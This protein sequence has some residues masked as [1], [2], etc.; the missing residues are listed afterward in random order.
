MTARV[1]APAANGRILARIGRDGSLISLCAPQLDH[2]LIETHMYAVV[3]RPDGLRRIGGAGW[4]HDLQYMRGTNV[5]RVVS[6]HSQGINV[7]RRIA[8]IGESLQAAF[9]SDAA[10]EVGWEQGVG[11]VLPQA[12]IRFDRAWPEALDPPPLA[13]ATRPWV[14]ARVPDPAG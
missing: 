3:R 14:L 13:G 5:L 8:A 4:K 2:E 1:A 7:E 9:R 10:N 11:E 12:G 6:S